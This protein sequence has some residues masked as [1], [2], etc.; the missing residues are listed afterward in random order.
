MRTTSA[1]VSALFLL[2][3][4]CSGGDPTPSND[5]PIPVPTPKDGG[6]VGDAK[7]PDA[8]KDADAAPTCD[9]PGAGTLTKLSATKSQHYPDKLQAYNG[10]LYWA[11]A[12]AYDTSNGDS[13]VSAYVLAQDRY[14]SI[15]SGF[16]PASLNVNAYGV[17]FTDFNL[18]HYDLNGGNGKSYS[19]ISGYYPV[20]RTDG[21]Y[22][23]SFGTATDHSDNELYWTDFDGQWDS[24]H[25]L[26]GPFT[27]FVAADDSNVYFLMFGEP[28]NG[29]KETDLYRADRKLD[30]NSAAG[31]S[32]FPDQEPTGFAID[33]TSAYVA[34]KGSTASLGVMPKTG[35]NWTDLVVEAGIE[36]LATTTTYVYFTDAG[37]RLRRVAKDGTKPAEL[38][39]SPCGRVETVTT[40]GDTAY[41]IQS[42]EDTK[43]SIVI[44]SVK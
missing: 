43:N 5:N 9:L 41:F 20:L 34:T 30:L 29:P 39:F 17:Y 10:I 27:Q 3:P 2:L 26:V 19:T 11:T 33:S 22:E 14:F 38:V 25:G 18:Q 24:V 7:A 21:G 36:N 8:S 12:D 32:I 23:V 4:A 28:T 6:T 37:G 42:L 1:I 44:W 40:V 31:L 15:Y 35:G 13:Q 16:T